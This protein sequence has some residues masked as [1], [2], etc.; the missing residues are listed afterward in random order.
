MSFSVPLTILFGGTDTPQVSSLNTSTSSAQH[1]D[2]IHLAR[3]FKRCSL[4]FGFSIQYAISYQSLRKILGPFTCIILRRLRRWD[5]STIMG[6]RW[7]ISLYARLRILTFGFAMDVESFFAWLTSFTVFY[8]IYRFK[9]R[10]QKSVF[11][12]M[13]IMNQVPSRPIR[14]QWYWNVQQ[15]RRYGLPSTWSLVI[16]LKAKMFRIQHADGGEWLILSDFA[17]PE[18]EALTL[19]ELMV[20]RLR[21]LPFLLLVLVTIIG[22]SRLFYRGQ[23]RDI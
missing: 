9:S 1:I 12:L 10:R 6:H 3:A 21:C 2:F 22:I 13:R 7:R 15:W 19:E 16:H 4:L 8:Q 17:L 11:D 5:R 18:R 20:S 23:V 14:K